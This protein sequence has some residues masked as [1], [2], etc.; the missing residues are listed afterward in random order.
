MRLAY[1]RPTGYEVIEMRKSIMLVRL[2]EVR[3]LLLLKSLMAGYELSHFL[4]QN[5]GIIIVKKNNSKTKK[6]NQTIQIKYH[7][8]GVLK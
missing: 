1:C 6:P 5:I 7:L 2:I 4:I 8:G 3:P